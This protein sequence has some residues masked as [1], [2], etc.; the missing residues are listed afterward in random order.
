MLETLNEKLVHDRLPW[1][2]ERA[3]PL[4]HM[5]SRYP[6]SGKCVFRRAPESITQRHPSTS[7][8]S[9]HGRA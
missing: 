3:D 6:L 7:S 8:E 5:G 2:T 4:G 1:I 9:D